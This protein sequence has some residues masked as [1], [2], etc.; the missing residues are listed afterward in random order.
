MIAFKRNQYMERHKIIITSPDL[1][2]HF[3][4]N[5]R[6]YN[7]AEKPEIWNVSSIRPNLTDAELALQLSLYFNKISNE[8]SPLR[9]SQIPTTFDRPLPV[10]KPYQVAMRI[11]NIKKPKSKIKG[12]IF[13][14]LMTEYAQPLSD[15]YN[16]ITETF[17][18][19][20]IW[21]MEIVTV[22]PKCVNPE[23]FDQLRNISCTL[24][25]SKIYE[26]SYYRG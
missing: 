19:P 15:I 3:F 25:T 14:S 13:P 16:R 10:L 20:N 6:A 5:V 17:I 7:S 12:D 26:S 1:S 8:F 11:K 9:S 24:L 21:K 22:I 4:K 18:W 23:S 2:A